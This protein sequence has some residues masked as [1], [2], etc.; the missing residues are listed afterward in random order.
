MTV[1]SL[2]QYV[3]KRN[4]VPLGAKHSLRNMLTR[5]LGAGSF[6][7]FWQYWNPIWGYYLYRKVMQ[8]S[9]SFL[10]AWLAVIVTFF[11]SGALHDLAIALVKW[12]VFVFFTPWF[13]LMGAMVVVSKYFSI[14]YSKLP[15]FARSLINIAWI[16]S[17]FF[18]TKLFMTL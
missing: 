8:P 5:A 7:V 10:P 17:A 4:G 9:S 6:P 2:A 13:T 11:I 1:A 18:T 14:S 15:W 16:V 3:K 12:Q